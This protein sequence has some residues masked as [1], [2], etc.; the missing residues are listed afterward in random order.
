MRDQR[1]P[2]SHVAE[3]AAVFDSDVTK[4]YQ[5]GQVEHG[6]RLWEKPVLG[7]MAEE[8]IDQWT[9]FHTANEQAQ[10]VTALLREAFEEGD[11]SKVKQALNVMETGNVAGKQLED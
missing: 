4:K 8:V 10:L 11:W 3:I 6:G 7:F 5:A 1:T 2:E 9:Y